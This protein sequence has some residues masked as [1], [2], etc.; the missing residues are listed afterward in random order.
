MWSK[1]TRGKIFFSFE[2]KENV[3]HTAVQRQEYCHAQWKRDLIVIQNISLMFCPHK[4]TQ[5]WSHLAEKKQ[6]A[7]PR[8]IHGIL[9]Q[10]HR[11]QGAALILPPWETTLCFWPLIKKNKNTTLPPQLCSKD[12]NQESRLFC[13]LKRMGYEPSHLQWCGK[14]EINTEKQLQKAAIKQMSK[15][16]EFGST[17]LRGVATSQHWRQQNRRL[18]FCGLPAWNLVCKVYSIGTGKSLRTLASQKGTYTS[19]VPAENGTSQ[20]HCLY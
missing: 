16:Y 5:L 20:P 4:V 3:I 2:G 12:S 11:I 9:H 10:N 13:Q 7:N 1:N 19:A 6:A 8:N 15:A 14:A 17:D 18:G